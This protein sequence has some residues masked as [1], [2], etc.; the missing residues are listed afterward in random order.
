[1][2][3]ISRWIRHTRLRRRRRQV[4]LRQQLMTTT[5]PR[6]ALHS[7]LRP[8]LLSFSPS[9][10]SLLL[11]LSVFLSSLLDWRL[12]SDR[13]SKCEQQQALPVGRRSSSLVARLQLLPPPA[14]LCKR[15]RGRMQAPLRQL[16]LLLFPL[17]LLPVC[18]CL[19]RRRR[20]RRLALLCVPVLLVSPVA[21]TFTS[22]YTDTLTQTEAVVRRSPFCWSNG[23]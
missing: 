17:N 23:S 8:F 9:P 5:L 10:S 22:I 2:K 18:V 11:I 14:S 15:R 16:L 6:D 3:D 12:A 19:C 4:L 13:A 20:P 1:M 7:L 21:L